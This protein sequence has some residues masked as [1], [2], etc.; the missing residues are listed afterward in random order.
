MHYDVTSRRVHAAIVAVEKQQVLH[1]LTVF[2]ASYPTS[3]AHAPYFH[4][5]SAQLYKIFRQHLNKRKK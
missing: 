5:W 4:L 3:N 2:V 1:I